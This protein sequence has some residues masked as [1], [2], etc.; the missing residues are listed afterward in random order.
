MG[1]WGTSQILHAIDNINI[2]FIADTDSGRKPDIITI[3]VAEHLGDKAAA[4]GCKADI[5]GPTLKR[6][7][8]N[9]EFMVGIGDP[10]TVGA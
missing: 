8:G 5:S 3:Q 2:G 1:L 6:Q 10:Q 9:I 7:K 4:L